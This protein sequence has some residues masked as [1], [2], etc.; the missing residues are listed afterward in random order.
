MLNS[1]RFKSFVN[2]HFL[3]YTCLLSFLR[4]ILNLWNG[5]N[6]R[7]TIMGW[8]IIAF[9]FAYIPL[10]V[11]FKKKI[12]PYFNLVYSLV[13]VFILA[14][15]STFLYN[16]STALFVLCISIMIKPQLSKPAIFL[17]LGAVSVAFA[18]ND[19]DLIHY[20]IHMV[21]SLWF[22][23]IVTYVLS[24]EFERK[25][26][27]LNEDEIRILEQLRSGKVYQKEVEGY[28]ENTV[29]RK[30]KAARERNGN[31][32]REE[33]IIAFDKKYPK[34]PENSSNDGR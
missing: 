29:Y 15:D 11:F 33:L 34:T 13:L 28:S 19:E 32:T 7:F 30:L 31:L 25:N 6:S 17:Y 5:F 10:A 3:F 9:D 12:F 18:I 23:G 1:I 4:G 2:D 22:I 16:N 8:I 27:I 21:R 24:N 14:F 20:F 26:L